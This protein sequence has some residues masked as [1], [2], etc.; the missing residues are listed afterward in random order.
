MCNKEKIFIVL[1]LIEI[2]S[3]LLIGK[4]ENAKTNFD[5]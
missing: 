2:V 1:S 4:G 5:S 3:L